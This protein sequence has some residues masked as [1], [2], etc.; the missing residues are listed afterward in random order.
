MYASH[1]ILLI[2]VAKIC[3]QGHFVPQQKFRNLTSH[4][5]CKKYWDSWNTHIGCV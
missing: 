5:L 2:N 3:V 1:L 4:S